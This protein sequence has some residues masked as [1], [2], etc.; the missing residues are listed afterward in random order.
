MLALFSAQVPPAADLSPQSWNAADRTRV[1]ALQ[2]SPFPP[3]AGAVQGSTAIICD[4]GSPIAVY[5]GMEALKK[6]GTAADAA[7]TVALT[8]IAT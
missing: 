6:G 3:R 4:T 7:A 1:E 2:M 5:A 8:Q